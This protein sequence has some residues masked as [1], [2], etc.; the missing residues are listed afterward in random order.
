[1]KITKL[2]RVIGMLLITILSVSL[3][4]GCSTVGPDLT[5]DLF[6]TSPKSETKYAEMI[7]DPESIFSDGEITIIDPDGGSAYIFEVVN[8]TKEEIAV[9][10]AECK[11]KGFN[12]VA[13]HNDIEFGAYVE[14]GEYWV[15]LNLD[16]TTNHLYVVCQ[17]S[18][19]N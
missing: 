3:F 1:M 14:T 4:V 8:F 7:P 6:S 12:D 10:V 16:T 17:E 18:N 5:P 13:Y 15:Q 11:N 2:Q 19:D 9:Y